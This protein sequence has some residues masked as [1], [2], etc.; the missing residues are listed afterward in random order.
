MN[1]YLGGIL[2]ALTFAAVVIFFA[3]WLTR[4]HPR[5]RDGKRARP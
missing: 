1:W 3:W 4:P 5:R 2:G